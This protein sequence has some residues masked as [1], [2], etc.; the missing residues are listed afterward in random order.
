MN[1]TVDVKEQ[2]KRD[3]ESDLTYRELARKHRMSL[4]DI[5]ELLKVMA[6][7]SQRKC[8][9]LRCFIFIINIKLQLLRLLTLFQLL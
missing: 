5:R 9:A 6:K 8:L 7:M 4:H 2:I 1:N 3:Y